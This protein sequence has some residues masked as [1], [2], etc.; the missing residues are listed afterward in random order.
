MWGRCAAEE[1]WGSAKKGEHERHLLA[2]EGIDE[3]LNGMKTG[4]LKSK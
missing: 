2:H 4:H 1:Q 3:R